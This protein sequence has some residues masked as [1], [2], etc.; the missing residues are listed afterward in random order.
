MMIRFRMLKASVFT[1]LLSPVA[2]TTASAQM[3][4][5]EGRFPEPLEKYEMPPAYIYRL[6][7]S[8]RM[9]SP[10]G[11][12]VSYQVNVDANGNNIVGDAANEPSISVNPTD[13]NK[14]A[15][16]WRQFDTWTSNFREA[17]YGYTTDTGIHWHFPG[18]LQNGV[19]RSDPVTNSDETGQFFYLSLLVSTFCG[20]IWRST[21]G[22]QSWA[23]RSPNGGAHSGDK[24]WFTI[25]KT[26]GSMGHGFQYQFWTEFFAC[27]FGGFSRSI[28]GGATWQTPISIPNSPQWGTLDVASNGYL[29]IGGGNSGSSFWCI[30]STNAQNPAVTPTFDQVTTV[31]MGGTL[32]YGPP[33]NPDG[34]AGQIFLAVDRSGGPT[35]NNIYMMAT[36]R[37]TG[38][39]TGTDVMFARSTDGG[40]SF[41]APR[42]IND[43]PINH[44]KYHW[45]GTLSVAP[46]GRIDSVWFDTRNAANNTDSQLFY[47]F[48][49]DGGVTWAP[50][51]AVSNSFTPLEGWP[52]QNKIGDYITIVSDNTGGNVAYS[53]TFNFNPTRGQH[54]QDVYYVRVAPTASV[55]TL[56]G[57][58]S[59]LTH[60]GAGTFDISMPLT[61]V[62][63]VEDRSS[64][65]YNAVFTFDGPVTS[66]QVLV[67]SGTA[68]VGPILFT[69]NTMTAQ[70]TG[71][72]SAEVVTLR[73]QNING[74]G[75]PHGDVPF[76]FL[77]ADVNANRIVDRPDQQQLQADR[78]QPITAANFRDD[79]NLS[80][81]IDRPDLQSVQVNRGHSIP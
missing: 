29:F 56:L 62:S 16:G 18:V 20:D 51:V 10:Y 5:P 44:N 3:L 54:E 30:R 49:T 75:Q 46:N 39:G 37:P 78:G 21:D 28:D 34:L 70:L 80:G 22:G 19:F 63:G 81:I 12:F 32:W 4:P 57:A 8:P 2:L 26:V 67:L 36:V 14:M 45:F 6:E 55:R 47:S 23:L 40:L 27:D 31:N 7:S 64:S 68:T 48:S 53:A 38:F 43:D 13:G 71:V 60:A 72:T 74:D 52:S 11:S 59:R 1:C 42:R 65:T 17:G 79:I 61:G 41:S 77:T 24:E 25:D 66:G 73:V 9:V 33:V 50:N 69:G 35:N 58:G 76:G 15:V